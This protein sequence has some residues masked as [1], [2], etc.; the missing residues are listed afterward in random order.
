ML[1][2]AKKRKQKS[3]DLANTR[4]LYRRVYYG[5]SLSSSVTI[6]S[7]RA[8]SVLPGLHGSLCHASDQLRIPFAR[9]PETIRAGKGKHV[10]FMSENVIHS[11]NECELDEQ[12]IVPFYGAFRMIFIFNIVVFPRSILKERCPDKIL[13]KIRQKLFQSVQRLY[14]IKK[15]KACLT[16]FPK[17]VR[18]FWELVVKNDVHKVLQIIPKTRNTKIELP[19]FYLQIPGCCSST[20]CVFTA[21]EMRTAWT[22]LSRMIVSCPIIS[23]LQFIGS[24]SVFHEIS[25]FVIL[26]Q[27]LWF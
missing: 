15:D 12:W 11:W 8:L 1:P 4:M 27:I 2:L 20:D 18:L 23:F 26:F 9:I 10:C 7:Y 3:T 22:E 5:S 24:A 13:R 21:L 6:R 17:L 16:N 14:L 19:F 25:V